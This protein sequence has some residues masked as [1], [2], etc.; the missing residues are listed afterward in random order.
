MTTHP[1]QSG[2][3]VAINDNIIGI[4]VGGGAGKGDFNIGRLLTQEVADVMRKWT[5]E[6]EAEP[7]E[8]H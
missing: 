4:H 2:C 1:G 7:F 8:I 5:D 6:M 3:P